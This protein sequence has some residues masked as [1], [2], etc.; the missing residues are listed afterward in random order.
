M[1]SKLVATE[2]RM[3]A[4]MGARQMQVNNGFS[5]V[6]FGTEFGLTVRTA[7]VG[8]RVAIPSKQL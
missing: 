2:V 1:F 7:M 5:L 6:D 4:R 8:A 3:T